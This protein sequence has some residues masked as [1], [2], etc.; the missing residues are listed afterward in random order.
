MREV[1]FALRVGGGLCPFS[2]VGGG[3]PSRWWRVMS[4]LV[5]GWLLC[6][7]LTEVMI[8]GGKEGMLLLFFC[9][10]RAHIPRGRTSCLLL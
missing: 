1:R 6:Y 2:L 5:E 8:W 9:P 10:E 7:L 4:L 3:V